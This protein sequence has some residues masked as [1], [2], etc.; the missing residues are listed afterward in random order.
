[1]ERE[2]LLQLGILIFS[3]GIFYVLHS[4]PKRV[5]TKLRSKTRP[6]NQAHRHFILGAQLLSR[7]RSTKT[8]STAFNLAKSAADEADKALAL[9]P[10]DPAAHILKAMAQGLMGH[11]T[12]AVKS[13][14]TALSPPAVKML[15]GTEKGDALFKRAELQFEM[16]RKRRVD[17]AISDLVEAVGLNPDNCKAFCLLGRCYEIKGLKE[18]AM[19]AFAAALKIE[20]GFVEARDGLGRVGP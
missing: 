16:N 5:F 10:R 11:K 15:S 14:D 6:N 12:A 7:A 4:L 18:D 20:P 2:I 1:M 3:L 13:L 19:N 9:E 17:S 8:K